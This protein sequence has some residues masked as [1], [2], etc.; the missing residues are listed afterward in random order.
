MS[1]RLMKAKLDKFDSVDPAERQREML[2]DLAANNI[3]H[4]AAQPGKDP[5]GTPFVLLTLPTDQA[6]ENAGPR[7]LANPGAATVIAGPPPAW[8][9][10]LNIDE[11]AGLATD[12][13]IPA[14]GLIRFGKG[15]LNDGADYSLIGYLDGNEAW[16]FFGQ[17]T[18]LLAV[19]HLTVATGAFAVSAGDTVTV[20]EKTTGAT[21]VFTFAT[22]FD[23]DAEPDDELYLGCADD[24]TLWRI[25]LTGSSSIPWDEVTEQM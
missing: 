8:Q 4:G 17:R 22:S 6:Q 18:K 12:I 7:L 19:V 1:E 23:V 25:S 24:G 14:S 20:K 13:D 9:P 21:K 2:A 11:T 3:P 5:D 16:T 10:Y 15:D